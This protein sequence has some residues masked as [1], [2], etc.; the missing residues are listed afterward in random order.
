VAELGIPKLRRECLHHV[1]V[2]NE[3]HLHRILSAYLTYFHQAR[4]HLSLGRN[5][6]APRAVEPAAHGCVVSEL[7]VGGLQHCY[8]RVA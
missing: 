4:A 6:P 8:R 1:I 3:R 2:L 5:A 7:M